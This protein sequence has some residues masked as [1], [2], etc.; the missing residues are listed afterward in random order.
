MVGNYY[1]LLCAYPISFGRCLKCVVACS[2]SQPLDIHG[3]LAYRTINGVQDY[4]FGASQMD[5]TI[6]QDAQDFW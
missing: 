5:R 2:V 1:K 4:W 3:R 6:D